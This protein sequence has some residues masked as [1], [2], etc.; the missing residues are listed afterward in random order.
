MDTIRSAVL[1]LLMFSFVGSSALA[2]DREPLFVN[3]ASDDYRAEMALIFSK[4]QLERQH[5][6]TVFLSD[7]AVY[8]AS[9]ANAA[10]FKEHQALLNKLMEEGANV[11]ICGLCLKHYG[12][13]EK[14]LLPGVKISSPELV[15]EALFK[16][17]IRTLSW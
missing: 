11:L 4:T 14:D 6:V 7:R 1:T 16:Q 8:I 15:D 12:V 9:K 3:T 13:D 2:G 5:P 10:Q 17:N